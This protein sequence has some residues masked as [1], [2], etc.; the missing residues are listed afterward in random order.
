MNMWFTYEIPEII[1]LCDLKGTVQL[2][3]SKDMSVHVSS[4]T[5]YDFNTLMP[6]VWS[7][8]TDKMCVFLH[9]IINMSDGF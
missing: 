2:D 7:C 5:S 6:V 9:L 3:C 1:L 8:G 4:C